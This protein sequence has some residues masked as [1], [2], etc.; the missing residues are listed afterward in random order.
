MPRERILHWARHHTLLDW[1]RLGWVVAKPNAESHHDFYSVTVEFLC[2]CKEPPIPHEEEW[3]DIAG[4]DGIY[5][6]SSLGSVRSLDRTVLVNST[7]GTHEK[8]FKGRVLKPLYA[9]GYAQVCLY[10]SDGASSRRYVSHLVAETFL[11][12][13]PDGAQVCHNDGVRSNNRLKNL[14]YGTPK[15]NT[16]DKIAHGTLVNGESA[17]QARLTATDVHEIRRAATVEDYAGIADR[18][19]ISYR[20]VQSLVARQSWK[21]LPVLPEEVGT[22]EGD[23][24]RGRSLAA[25]RSEWATNLNKSRAGR[26]GK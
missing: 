20:T 2:D 17:Y 24:M 25:R 12:P 4:H 8:L 19:G 22:P 18:F 7:K 6:V 23:A 16:A 13:R 14:R 26:A 21:H 10:S 11:G 15:E 1:V 3:R 9:N 5:Q